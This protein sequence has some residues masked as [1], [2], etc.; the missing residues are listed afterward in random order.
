MTTCN[1]DY[2]KHTQAM[3]L[4]LYKNGL[5]Y[6]KEA[7]VNWDPID[8]TVLANEQVDSQGK[9]WR[10]GAVVEKKV[11]KQWFFK[12]THYAKSL[13][14]DLQHLNGWP[15]HVKSQQANWIG[16]SV[17]AEFTFPITGDFEQDITVYTSR[18]DTLFGVQF[19]ALSLRHPISLLL[20]KTDANL[21]QFLLDAKSLPDDTK[22][23]Y[24]TDLVATNILS[25]SSVPV[26]V[27]PYVLDTYGHGAVMG[28]PGHDVR[29]EAFMTQNC[30]DMDIIQVI[31]SHDGKFQSGKGLLNMNCGEYAGMTVESGGS[32]IIQTMK[33]KGFGKE[34]VQYRLRDWL[35]SR[36]RYWGAPIPMIH[37]ETCGVLPVPDAELPVVLPKNVEINIKGGSPLQNAQE[38]VNTSCPK[39][40]APAKR[41]TD[42]M[43]TFVDSSWY[44]LRYLDSQNKSQPFDYEI[45]SRNMP[46]DLYIGGVEH[47]ILHL[48]YS[49][50]FSKVLSST[51]PRQ[52]SSKFH[53]EPF[54]RLVTQGMVHGRTFT[55][56]T[57]GRFLRPTEVD[58]GSHPPKLIDGGQ[59]VNISYEKM[60]KSKYNGLD[61][62]IAIS[63][64][65]ADVVRAHVLFAAPV[66]DVL[67]WDEEKI[68]G[69]VRWLNKVWR[70]VKGV[71]EMGSDTARPATATVDAEMQKV[72]QTA[73]RDATSQ[74]EAVVSLNTLITTLI[75]LTTTLLNNYQKGSIRNARETVSTLLRLMAPVTPAIASEAWDLLHPG[76]S[77]FHAEWPTF[78][79]VVEDEE[80]ELIVQVNGKKK[81]HSVRLTKEMLSWSTGK[82]E[83]LLKIEGEKYGTVQ[84]VILAKNYKVVNFV[85]QK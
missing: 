26:Y 61:P 84:R 15:Q 51:E 81:A 73:V 40:N 58:S 13:L 57:T 74:L 9:S 67:E 31:D 35:V 4:H 45:A 75:K 59:P 77:V 38:W 50:F 39:C 72:A 49:R 1:A 32:A 3:F 37:C 70:L 23:G 64:Y 27:A 43:D 17:G 30:P 82:L 60:S 71:T 48:L 69:M 44:Y 29:D 10:S 25:N 18:P 68:I 8:Q 2:Y 28:V 42:T 34:S 6:R 78:Q 21:A 20:A 46:V 76:E 55:H 5:A 14:D 47:A 19:L 62:E 7:E 22:I 33:D 12:I 24:K 83:A 80:K 65:G 52:Y 41:D 36:Q 54:R 85:I 16:Q 63:K 79:E 66:G 56:P 53:G 11:L